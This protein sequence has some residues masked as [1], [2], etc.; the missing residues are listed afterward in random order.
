MYSGGSQFACVTMTDFKKMKLQ[1]PLGSV[2]QWL[3]P[4]QGEPGFREGCILNLTY[5]GTPLCEHPARDLWPTP[6][7]QLPQGPSAVVTPAETAPVAG[8]APAAPLPG[9]IRR[10]RSSAPAVWRAYHCMVLG[11]L[12]I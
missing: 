5:R 11:C 3:L 8:R 4:K 9:T 2:Q 7:L 1:L 12:T 10:S 6:P